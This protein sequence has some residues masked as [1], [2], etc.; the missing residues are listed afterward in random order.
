MIAIAAIAKLTIRDPPAWVDLMNRM[1]T[2]RCIHYVASYGAH[3]LSTSASGIEQI[4][5]LVVNVLQ[6][7]DDGHSMRTK[8]QKKQK[9]K[10]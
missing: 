8:S 5:V 10:R 2:L 1:W 6:D 7:H 4:V 3:S 9:G